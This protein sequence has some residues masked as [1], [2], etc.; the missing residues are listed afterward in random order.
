M[1]T[2]GTIMQ[3]ENDLLLES[4]VRTQPNYASVMNHT[5]L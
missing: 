2:E 4:L 1:T 5:L 3:G